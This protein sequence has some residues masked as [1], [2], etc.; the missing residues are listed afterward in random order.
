MNKA[1]KKV[2][3]HAGHNKNGKIACGA[4]DWIDE[5]KEARVITKKVVSLLKKNKVAAVNCTVNNGTSQSDV[6]KKICAK[7]NSQK[8]VDLNISIHFNACSHS[9]KDGKT[10]GVEVLSRSL[11]KGNIRYEVA[12]RICQKISAIGFRNR[13]VKQDMH[14]YV[15][16]N[17]TAPTILIEVCFVTDQ[18]DAALY[19]KNKYGVAKAI[20]DAV[21]EYNK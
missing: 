5:S 13:G 19:K 6:L 3:V 20:V 17:T 18:D 8:N 10:T 15:L 9:V 4:S 21:L 7:C 14:L 1:I 2:T 11:E 16:N 12:N